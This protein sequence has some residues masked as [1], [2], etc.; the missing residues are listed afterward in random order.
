M[1]RA[2]MI[3]HRGTPILLS[4]LSGLRN[5]EEL[6][7][8]VRLGGELLQTQAKQPVLV[9]V[10]VT[11]VEYNVE[12]FAVLQQSV[13]ANRGF[14]R[15]RAIVGLPSTA[16]VPFEIVARMSASP[17]ESFDDLDTAKEWLV[18]HA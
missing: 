8:A 5:T 12:A 1:D 13:A 9:L 6:Q 10:D 14:V 18:S 3:E 2:R 4:D 7:R 16:T 15:A 17:M 11:G